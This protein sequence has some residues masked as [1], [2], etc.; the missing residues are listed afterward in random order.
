MKLSKLIIQENKANTL[1]QDVIQFIQK[2]VK[3]MNDDEVY[4]FHELLKKWTNKGY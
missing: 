2:K 3:T 1:L 4:E